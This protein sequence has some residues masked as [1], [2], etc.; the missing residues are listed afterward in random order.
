L[1]GATVAL[2]VS[3]PKERRQ[4]QR[5]YICRPARSNLGSHAI[6]RRDSRAFETPSNT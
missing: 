4:T 6:R 3:R 1:T 2:C 5:S